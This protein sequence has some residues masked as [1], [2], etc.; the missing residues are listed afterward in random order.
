MKESLCYKA[1]VKS[2]ERKKNLKIALLQ[3]NFAFKIDH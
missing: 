3:D 1:I 2:I